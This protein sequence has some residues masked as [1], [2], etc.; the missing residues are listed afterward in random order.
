MNSNSVERIQSGS[1]CTYP[2][3]LTEREEER[4]SGLLL[5]ESGP[6]SEVCNEGGRVSTFYCEPERVEVSYDD[7]FGTPAIGETETDLSS[8]GKNDERRDRYR[9][10]HPFDYPIGTE[11]KD[12]AGGG[13]SR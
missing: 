10:E 1:L 6:R 5:E 8:V 13:E 12:Q 7:L 2:T 4:G 3:F 9:D 11:H